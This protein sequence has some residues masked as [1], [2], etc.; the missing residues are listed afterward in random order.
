MPA[1]RA[2]FGYTVY[3]GKAYV[4]GGGVTNVFAFDGVT[5][6]EVAGLPSARSNLCAAVLDGSLY[7]L[8]GQNGSNCAS[9]FRFDGTSWTT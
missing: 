2:H 6:S 8:G 4:I 9:V 3:D 5:W 7:A 1:A